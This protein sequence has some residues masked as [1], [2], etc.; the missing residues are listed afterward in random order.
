PIYML[1]R[2]IWLLAVV[3]IFTNE[4]VKFL[5]LLAEQQTK[6]HNVIYQNHLAL[7]YLPFSLSNCCLQID[8]KGKVTE[9]IT[10][11]MTKIAHVPVQTWKGWN[12]GEL[13]EGW[14]SYLGGFKTLV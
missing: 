7:D 8:D 5:N 3:E 2:I 1:N 4:M 11:K 13:L 10:R 6:M 14:F 12:P 9:E